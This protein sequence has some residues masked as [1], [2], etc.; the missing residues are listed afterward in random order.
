M[1][2]D[3]TGVSHILRYARPTSILEDGS[4]GGTA[5]QLRS[6]ESCLSVNWLEFKDCSEPEQ[7]EEIVQLSRLQM[8][9]NGR[10][11]KLHVGPT[12]RHLHSVL[13]GIRFVH[14][15]LDPEG[16]HAAD[17]S[18][19]GVM[20]LPPADSPLAELIGDVMAEC[21]GGVFPIPPGAKPPSP[22]RGR[23][24]KNTMPELIPDTPEN[25]ARALLTTPPKDE[26]DWDY[27]KERSLSGSTLLRREP[28]KGK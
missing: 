20:G 25:I 17:P 19:S 9:K 21:V 23:P 12:K 18:H 10:L 27:L 7:L 28:K 13:D 8:R 2:E 11:A 5:F 24:V 22:Q 1:F 15:P 16:D 3:L 14:C 26:G 6:Q 4:V